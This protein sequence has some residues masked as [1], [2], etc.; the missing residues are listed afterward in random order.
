MCR[1][2]WLLMAEEHNPTARPVSMIMELSTQALR[3]T[4][5]SSC[6]TAVISDHL[7]QDAWLVLPNLIPIVE[8]GS[9]Q[10]SVPGRTGSHGRRRIP[11]VSKLPQS[12][13]LGVRPD[14]L[15]GIGI[16]AQGQLETGEGSRNDYCAC[17]WPRWGWQPRFAPRGLVV[18]S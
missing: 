8:S 18:G 1:A 5:N 17:S 6:W 13:V 9:G 16:R 4:A 12:S 3:V 2:V 14:S 11:L 7:R 15:I 10:V